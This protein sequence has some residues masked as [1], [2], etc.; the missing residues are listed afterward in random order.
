MLANKV[1]FFYVDNSVVSSTK[2]VWLQWDLD[3]LIGIFERFRLWTNGVE[4][5]LMMCQHGSI[6][7]R[8]SIAT[9]GWKDDQQGGP[10]LQE[11]TPEV[12]V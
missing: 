7:G 10:S 5:V 12:G 8:Q 1:A 2:P 4:T 11:A 6:A 9:Y 3:V